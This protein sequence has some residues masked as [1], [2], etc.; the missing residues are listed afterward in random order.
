M[1]YD[2][3]TQLIRS[4]WWSELNVDYKIVSELPRRSARGKV[5]AYVQEMPHARRLRSGRG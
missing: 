3:M 4:T 2:S 1:R 5:A